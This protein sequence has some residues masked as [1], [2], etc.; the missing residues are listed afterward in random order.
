MAS[1][2]SFKKVDSDAIIDLQVQSSDIADNTIAAA[3]IAD[4]AVTGAKIAGT[5]TSAKINPT[6]DISGKTVTYRP[7]VNA[8]ISATAS[9][10]GTK[11]ATGAATGKI[12]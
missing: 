7:I 5:V 11:L 10:A 6:I 2:S 1:Y 8:D 3:K 9:I 12:K 4:D